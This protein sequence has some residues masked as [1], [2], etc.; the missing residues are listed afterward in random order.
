MSENEEEE[1]EEESTDEEELEV[2]VVSVVPLS[3]E[4]DIEDEIITLPI[5]PE[6]DSTNFPDVFTSLVPNLG[7]LRDNL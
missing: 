4:S 6:T 5:I 3:S 7:S 2:D 1:E